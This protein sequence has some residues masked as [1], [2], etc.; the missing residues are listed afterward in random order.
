M[1]SDTDSLP[2]WDPTSYLGMPGNVAHVASLAEL[3]EA[4]H[5]TGVKGV[6]CDRGPHTCGDL[7]A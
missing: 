3:E 4:A 7:I 1:E 2:E 6:I 5:V